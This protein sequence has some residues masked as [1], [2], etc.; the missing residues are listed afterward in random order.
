MEHGAAI[1]LELLLVHFIKKK[2]NLTVTKGEEFTNVEIS[3]DDFDRDSEAIK[4]LWLLVVLLQE[5]DAH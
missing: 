1:N 2:R 5:P 3:A 4:G